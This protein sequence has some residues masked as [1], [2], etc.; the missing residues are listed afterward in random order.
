MRGGGMAYEP[1]T[2]PV[3]RLG[4]PSL[5]T[6]AVAERQLLGNIHLQDV[7][8]PDMHKDDPHFFAL[9]LADILTG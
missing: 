8:T 2:G 7:S 1:T 9:R 5:A 3:H 4:L 6:H